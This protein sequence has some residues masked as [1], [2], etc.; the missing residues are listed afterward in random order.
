M[1]LTDSDWMAY[2]HLVKC[3]HTSESPLI[4]ETI[5]VYAIRCANINKQDLAF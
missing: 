4:R 5:L 2:I 3:S 1:L